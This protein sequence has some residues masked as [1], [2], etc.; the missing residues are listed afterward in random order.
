METGPDTLESGRRK[1]PEREPER[2]PGTESMPWRK[3]RD[4]EPE[5]ERD[6]LLS[7]FGSGDRFLGSDISFVEAGVRF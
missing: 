5:L 4:A 2:E 1:L 6:R 7:G 3:G